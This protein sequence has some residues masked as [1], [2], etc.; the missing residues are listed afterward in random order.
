MTNDWRKDQKTLKNVHAHT[1]YTFYDS[2]FAFFLLFSQCNVDKG[3]HT[4]QFSLNMSLP[5]ASFKKKKSLSH[6]N[7]FDFTS[8]YNR[9][10]KKIKNLYV[11]QLSKLFLWLFILYKRN[12]KYMLLLPSLVDA[13][14]YSFDSSVRHSRRVIS[15]F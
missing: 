2:C 1:F 15:R 10:L 6:E 3:P 7:L 11:F 14:H 9:S 13:W 8:E 12:K 5:D 4:G